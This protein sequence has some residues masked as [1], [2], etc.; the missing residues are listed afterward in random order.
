MDGN[1]G[2]NFLDKVSLQSPRAW[3]LSFVSNEEHLEVVCVAKSKLLRLEGFL[4]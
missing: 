4:G 2:W 1:K 3:L